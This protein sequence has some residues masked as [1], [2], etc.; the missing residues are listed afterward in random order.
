MK[1]ILITGSLGY[2]GSMLSQYLIAKNYSVIGYDTGFFKEAYLYKP[3]KEN[4]VL[5][6]VRFIEEKDLKNVDALIHLAGI[7][8]DPVGKLKPSLVY[9]PTRD[10][11]LK[12]A[13]MC[14]KMGVKFIFAS[15]CSVYGIGNN[16]S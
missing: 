1:R 7:S 12:I 15:S 4:F 5:S 11:S 3:K 14:K 13:K 10:Y 8:N 16:F 6:D 2:L 9:D